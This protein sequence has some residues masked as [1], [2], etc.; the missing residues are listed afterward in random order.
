MA[1]TIWVSKICEMI[2]KR[3]DDCVTPRY[4]S[5]I[6]H[7]TS[8]FSKLKLI[9]PSEVLVSSDVRR[10]NDLTFYNV[11]ARQPFSI[12]WRGRLNFSV[13]ELRDSIRIGQKRSYR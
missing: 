3:L 8:S 7:V 2:L 12:C 11:S 9:H 13:F 10:A 1:I 6:S 4:R 5:N